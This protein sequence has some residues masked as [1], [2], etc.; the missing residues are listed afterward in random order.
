MI[1]PA[2]TNSFLLGS[3]VLPLLHLG[4]WRYSCQ[5]TTK[6]A[7]FCEAF[8]QTAICIR[9]AKEEAT[10]ILL[11]RFSIL[12]RRLSILAE[13]ECWCHQCCIVSPITKQEHNDELVLPGRELEYGA[14]SMPIGDR[15]LYD[16]PS[17][18]PW[19]QVPQGL[20]TLPIQKV[21]SACWHL[22]SCVRSRLAMAEGKNYLN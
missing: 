8:G 11:R 12:L 4:N 15:P 9:C 2:L 1:Q 14:V 20:G 19:E 5:T 3:E 16:G 21:H 6:L 17:R 13:F 7:A 22:G 10:S 18:I